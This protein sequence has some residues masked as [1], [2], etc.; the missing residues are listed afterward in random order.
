VIVVPHYK[1]STCLTE[2]DKKSEALRCESVP[3]EKPRASL[4]PGSIVGKHRVRYYLET[5]AMSGK[6]GHRGGYTAT[7]HH[8]CPVPVKAPPKFVVTDARDLIGQKKLTDH[9]L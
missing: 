2:F 5:K 9:L 7:R 3:A 6:Q 8:I 4:A 1:C